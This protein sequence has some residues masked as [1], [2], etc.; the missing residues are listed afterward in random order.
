MNRND[1]GTR[2]ATLTPRCPRCAGRLYR[3][4]GELY[5]ADCVRYTLPAEPPLGPVWYDARTTDGNYVHGGTDLGALAEWVLGVLDPQGDVLLT[6][7]AGKVVAV[8]RGDTGAV[9]RV[10][11]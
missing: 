6:T 3:C 7:P 1:S 4:R 2:H 9:V 5:C 8:V 10:R 11:P